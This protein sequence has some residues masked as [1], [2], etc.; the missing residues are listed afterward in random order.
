MVKQIQNKL[1][2]TIL[3]SPNLAKLKSMRK[4]EIVWM[5]FLT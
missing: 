4:N 5:T 3:L 1:G 2:K